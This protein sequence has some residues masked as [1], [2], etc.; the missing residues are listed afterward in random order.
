MNYGL[1]LARTCQ[2]T[3]C[4]PTRTRETAPP[5]LVW[6]RASMFHPTATCNNDIDICATGRIEKCNFTSFVSLLNTAVPPVDPFSILPVS[7][8]LPSHWSSG[9]SSGPTFP[10]SQHSQLHVSVVRAASQRAC[11]I[12]CVALQLL[13]NPEPRTFWRW[14]LV[15]VPVFAHACACVCVCQCLP[16][17]CVRSLTGV[18]ADEA[19]S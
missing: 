12:V 5:G 17:G 18:V 11:P 7:R 16:G 9:A 3:N 4:V 8:P 6:Q 19:T 2:S 13:P 1:L 14:R 15:S 10:Q